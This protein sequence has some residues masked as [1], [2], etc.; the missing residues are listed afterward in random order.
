MS[1]RPRDT[2]SEVMKCESMWQAPEPTLWGALHSSA[3]AQ[4]EEGRAGAEARLPRTGLLSLNFCPFVQSPAL[5]AQERKINIDRTRLRVH[6]GAAVFP[7]VKWPPPPRF[8]KPALD[9]S[10]SKEPR[11]R[12]VIVGKLAIHGSKR[13]CRRAGTPPLRETP[14]CHL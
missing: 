11:Q 10:G 12:T 4:A 14:G 2:Q 7:A 9:S 5:A 13:K 6:L 1:N 8:P 3:R